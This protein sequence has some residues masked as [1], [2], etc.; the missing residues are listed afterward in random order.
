[1]CLEYEREYYRRA[2]EARKAQQEAEERRKQQAKPEAPAKPA[3]AKPVK[4][5]VPA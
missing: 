2:E 5:P 1:M 3:D 4:Q